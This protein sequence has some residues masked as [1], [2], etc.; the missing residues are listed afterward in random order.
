[1]FGWGWAAAGQLGDALGERV[2]QPRVI[3]SLS[4]AAEK[5][6]ADVSAGLAHSAAVSDTGELY[7]FGNPARGRLGRGPSAATQIGLAAR[8][9]GAGLGRVVRVACGGYHTAAVTAARELF[10]FGRND[11][12]QLGTGDA[13]DR[14][15]PAPVAALRGRRVVLVACGGLHT[16]A[17]TET[18]ELFA[19]GA[20]DHG[21]L[22]IGAP[23]SAAVVDFAQVRLPACEDGVG[24][25]V[26]MRTALGGV[27][28]GS[29]HSVAL[30]AGRVYAWGANAK[31]QCGV[32]STEPAA[33]L[34]PVALA[35]FCDRS[36]VAVA[37]GLE[38]TA[39]VSADGLLFTWGSE[40]HGQGGHGAL[41]QLD[42]VAA[43]GTGRGSNVSNPH[44]RQVKEALAHVRCV[45][46]S[47]GSYHTLAMSDRGDLYSWGLGDFGQL[48]H[49][50]TSDL[51][52][53]FHLRGALQG[54]KI[55][56]IACGGRHTLV[57][58]SPAPI[59]RIP[60]S[61]FVD[62]FRAALEITE[63]SDVRLVASN[64]GQEV[65][66][67]RVLL[68]CKSEALRLAFKSGTG[69]DGRLVL[70]VDQHAAKAALE[71][72]YGD[73]VNVDAE[74]A[75]IP[76]RELAL[77]NAAQKLGL[78]S[79][80]KA[81]QEHI[82]TCTGGAAAKTH[83][84]SLSAAGAEADYRARAFQMR[85]FYNSAELSDV[86]LVLQDDEGGEVRFKAHKI[87]LACRSP[88]F[89]TMISGRFKE[90][91]E[92]EISLPMH[93]PSAFA[94][95]LQYMYTDRADLTEDDA[96]EV[97][98]MS[99]EYGLD[100]LKALCEEFI[101]GGIDVEN[102]AWLFEL[103]ERNRATQLKA[104]CEYFVLNKLHE[105]SQTEGYR[106]LSE[107]AKIQLSR[108]QVMSS[109]APSESSGKCLLQ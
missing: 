7:T 74:T 80:A 81:L 102:V 47:C 15:T 65:P 75:D 92:R 64:D 90:G 29:A 76:A 51:A 63:M 19:C 107:D 68:A 108:G 48:G 95:V 99:N 2:T 14:A 88:V 94:T 42:A 71:F 49:G 24:D 52:A 50:A 53:P 39:A 82:P 40:E 57:A 8:V 27:A 33:V 28:A 22:G 1:M 45:A 106:N 55:S 59:I 43:S 79:L 78:H 77:L 35:A 83:R 69:A 61:T 10:A 23:P 97:L 31:G 103:S 16:L 17:A 89:R 84:I 26:A 87:V 104:F 62:D 101:Q 72:I 12:G 32:G 86:E 6:I 38:H 9:A 70:D 20:N 46:V 56:S 98:L 100:Q 11:R 54:A 25:G 93:R 37:C 66:A 30:R 21:Q 60:P 36:V 5:R 67:H 41:S 73:S 4:A 96:V 105:V 34:A 58:C 3:R 18:G 91:S 44:P 13:A 109:A 85:T